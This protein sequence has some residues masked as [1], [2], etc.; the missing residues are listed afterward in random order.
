MA[1]TITFLR[2][3]HAAPNQE[4]RLRTLSD[5]G[6][7]QAN[8]RRAKLGNPSYET[9]IT[10][11]V[12]RTNDTARIV[13][14]GQEIEIL[15]VPFLLPP[16][17]PDIDDLFE[18]RLGYVPIQ[19]YLDANT[20]GTQKLIQYARQ[21]A[22][23]ITSVVTTDIWASGSDDYTVLVVGHAIVL[24]MVGLYISTDPWGQPTDEAGE[25]ASLMLSLNLAECEGFQL[26]VEPFKPP[27]DRYYPNPASLIIH[28]FRTLCD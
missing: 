15:E 2:H 10:S 3:G 27:I 21:A 7:A 12:A 5:R 13:S 17:D 1:N 24:P 14:G 11:G 20:L 18:K 28:G 8:E 19:A 26:D 9:I 16:P 6:K 4:D 25:V 23:E 22:E